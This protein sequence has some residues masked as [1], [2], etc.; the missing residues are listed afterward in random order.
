MSKTENEEKTLKHI[1]DPEQYTQRKRI[2]EILESRRAVRRETRQAELRDDISQDRRNVAAFVAVRNYVCNL[3]TLR[4]HYES[5]EHYWEPSKGADEIGDLSIG[6]IDFRQHANA[7]RNVLR[8]RE[9]HGTQYKYQDKD[10]EILGVEPVKITVKGLAD[11][12]NLNQ[13]LSTTVEYQMEAGI[14]ESKPTTKTTTIKIPVPREITD[15][16]FRLANRYISSIGVEM[17]PEDEAVPDAV[18]R[19]EDLMEHGP[20]EGDPASVRGEGD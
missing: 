9:T 15:R 12:I 8:R 19:Y 14:Y 4:Q 5:S 13:I 18:G 1:E 17:E 11:F 6:T 16:G 10:I 7:R 3:E 2:E 20:P